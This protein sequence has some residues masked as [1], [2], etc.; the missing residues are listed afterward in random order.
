M[1]RPACKAT[2][3]KKSESTRHWF[4]DSY[5]FIIIRNELVYYLSP[6]LSLPTINPPDHPAQSL[7]SPDQFIYQ[8]R[9][10]GDH[11]KQQLRN[12][13]SKKKEKSN[14]HPSAPEL[15]F[16]YFL[17]AIIWKK[18][19]KNSKPMIYP[20]LQWVLCRQPPP[21]RPIYFTLFSIT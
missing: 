8:N 9:I 15:N 16:V 21:V 14:E 13:P 2:A 7:E 6:V 20:S 18:N 19:Q 5:M 10:I 12:P 1:E 4:D 11:L 17:L 3:K